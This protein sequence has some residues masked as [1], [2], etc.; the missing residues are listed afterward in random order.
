MTKLEKQYKKLGLPLSVKMNKEND[1]FYFDSDDDL[2]EYISDYLSDTYGYC[3]FR[4]N[5]IDNG[6]NVTAYDIAWDISE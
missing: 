6:E 2:E 3:H 1:L 5:Y 4:F